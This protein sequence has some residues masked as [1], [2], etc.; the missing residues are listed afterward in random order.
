M[1]WL[2]AVLCGLTNNSCSHVASCLYPPY[3]PF[4]V[5][6]SSILVLPPGD[7]PSSIQPQL[8]TSNHPRHLLLPHECYQ[9]DPPSIVEILVLFYQADPKYLWAAHC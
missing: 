7:L 4:P 8:S 1:S 6:G 9:M 3:S 2:F 5:P